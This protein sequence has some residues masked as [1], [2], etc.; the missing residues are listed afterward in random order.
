MSSPPEPSDD[1]TEFWRERHIATL[2][3]SRADGTPHVVPVGVTV[4]EEFAVARVI[5]S[6]DSVKARN[7]RRGG[8]EGLPVAISQVDGRR[9][10][11]L[12]GRAVVRD[13]ADA[14][15][16]AERRYAE[17]YRTPRVNPKRVVLEVTLTRR[18]GMR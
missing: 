4:D 14:V 9:W 8:P 11:T 7:V 16:E 18:L 2:T 17:R 10:S 15:A 13:D 3:T 5:C 1:V 6:G 12:E